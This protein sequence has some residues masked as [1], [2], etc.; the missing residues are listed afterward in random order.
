MWI[1]YFKDAVNHRNV[2]KGLSKVIRFAIHSTH[3]VITIHE[4]TNRIQ[5]GITYNTDPAQKIKQRDL[6]LPFR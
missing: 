1:P 4:E 6:K 2:I 3:L 5:L